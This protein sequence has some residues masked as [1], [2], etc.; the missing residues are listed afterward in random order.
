MSFFKKLIFVFLLTGTAIRLSAGND[1][2]GV[3]NFSFGSGEVITFKVF[4]NVIGLYVDAG[5]ASF[6][7]SNTRLN[8]KP[9]YHIVGVGT[10]NPSYDWIFKVRDKYETYIDTTTLKPYRFVRHV[11]EGGYRKDELVNFYHDDLKAVSTKG[12]FPINN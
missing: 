12:T 8:N 9:V 11:E 3:S 4:Y 7:V 2:C 1:F 10:S 6:S 5:T